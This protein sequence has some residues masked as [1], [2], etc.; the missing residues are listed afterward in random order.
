MQD[1]LNEEEDDDSLYNSDEKV[2]DEVNDF[3][4]GD[5]TSDD[6]FDSD[7]EEGFGETTVEEKPEETE[8]QN[9]E[10]EEPVEDS[11]PANDFPETEAPVDSGSG[12]P[13]DSSQGAEKQS[14]KVM[15][16]EDFLSAK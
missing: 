2:S 10:V 15:S 16:F 4:E 6:D 5:D 7:S 13:Q 12:Q 8:T 3:D 11:D 14:F 9:D 1:Y